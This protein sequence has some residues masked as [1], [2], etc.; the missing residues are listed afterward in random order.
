MCMSFLLYVCRY[1]SVSLCI[2]CCV[3]SVGRDVVLDVFSSFVIY[4]V[5]SLYSLYIYL[6]VR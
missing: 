6:V 3:I 1:L 5:I 2:G 4:L